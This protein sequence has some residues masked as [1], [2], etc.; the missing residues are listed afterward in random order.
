[1][2]KYL[3]RLTKY[4]NFK[5]LCRWPSKKKKRDIKEQVYLYT[6][7]GGTEGVTELDPALV[8]FGVVE[9]DREE[10]E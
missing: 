6:P 3:M 7:C 10:K 4:Y 8:T 9:D 5:W 1:M 2:L